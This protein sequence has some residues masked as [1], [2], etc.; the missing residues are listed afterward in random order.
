[1]K[2]PFT[3]EEFLNVFSSYNNSVFPLQILFYLIAF[4]CI[5]LIFKQYKYGS[6]I[7]SA[8]LALYW[9]WMGLVYHII[10]FSSINKAAYAFGTLFIV[11]GFLFAAWGIFKPGITIRWNKSF[12]NYA[13]L[14]FIAYALFIYPL[15]GALSGHQ[16]PK[17]PTF[18][19]PCPTTIFTFGLLLFAGKKV[20]LPLLIIPFLWSIIGFNA[21]LSLSIYEDI[22][23]LAAGILGTIFIITAN[24]KYPGNNAKE[25]A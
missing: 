16:Y 24:K 2:F 5:F 9:I 6:K 7:I 4:L 13:G 12:Y 8:A 18:G 3:Q 25:K 17:A 21:A 22:G 10:F 1:M 14:L 11:Q 23:L 20:R 15:L 19:L